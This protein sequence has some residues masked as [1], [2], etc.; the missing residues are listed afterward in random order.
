MGV[1]AQRIPRRAAQHLVERHAIG[2]AGNIPQRVVKRRNRR[3]AHRPAAPEMVAIE[4]LPMVFP[5]QRIMADQHLAKLFDARF[6]RALA[7][8]QGRLAPAVETTIGHNL[9]QHPI[10]QAGPTN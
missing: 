6:H 1:E 3:I 7:P 10:A 5:A 9:D 8:L 2:F 4:P